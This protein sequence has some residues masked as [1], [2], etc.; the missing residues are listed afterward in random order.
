[1]KNGFISVVAASPAIRVADP[2]YNAAE[3][4]RV[5]AQCEQN[6]ARVLVFPELSLTGATCK[7]LFF[8]DALLTG[9]KRALA[10]Y[11]EN[12]KKLALVSVVGLPLLANNK[13]YNVAAVCYRGRVMGFVPKN[14]PSANDALSDARYF[15]GA[16]SADAISYVLFGGEEIPFRT[17]LL[18]CCEELSD[19]KLAVEI[20]GMHSASA[21][22]HAAKLCASGATL[23]CVPSAL[24]ETVGACDLRKKSLLADSRRLVCATV[25]AS[26]GCGESTTDLV[27]GGH[28]MI[29]QAGDP[30]AEALPFAKDS[31]VLSQIDVQTL[32][33]ER[34]RNGDFAQPSE[35][36]A[37]CEIY[38]SLPFEKTALTRVFAPHPFVPNDESE[39]FRRC[40]TILSIQAQ[41]LKARIERAYAKKLVLGISG[42]LDST[43]ALMVMARA[44]DL[45]ERPRTDIIAV[46]MPCLA[47]PS[48]PKTMQPFFAR[49]WGLT[50][51]AWISLTR[52]ISISVISDMIPKTAT[53]FMKMHRHASVR[54]S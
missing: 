43:L 35:E 54:R 6:G 30:L 45:L 12:T 24:P 9:S 23:L 31:T 39:L 33:Y 4:F 19:L 2:M 51:V 42:G 18:F 7:D 38:F 29:A 36:A 48:A 10:A 5:A 22:A 15:V 1:M 21:Y 47:P 40:E 46:T 25:L 8:S 52:S 28:C 53:W 32:S 49:S 20:G 17:D 27:F 16:A 44:M 37:C 41:G 26:A 14:A 3:L 11:L 34:R 13:L 50:S